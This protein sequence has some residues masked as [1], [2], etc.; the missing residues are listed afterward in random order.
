M[1]SRRVNCQ[2]ERDDSRSYLSLPRLGSDM[3]TP[4]ELTDRLV[5][6]TEEQDCLYVRYWLEEMKD[7]GCTEQAINAERE[8]FSTIVGLDRGTESRARSDRLVE[9]LLSSRSHRST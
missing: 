2:S 1:S 6:A 7:L 4:R 9:R 5:I 8:S 3:Y